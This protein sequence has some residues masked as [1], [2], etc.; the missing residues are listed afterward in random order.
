MH[1]GTLP[2]ASTHSNSA[3]NHRFYDSRIPNPGSYDSPIPIPDSRPSA[4]HRQHRDLLTIVIQLLGTH[5]QRFFGLLF[6]QVQA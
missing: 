1:I 6:E 5:D 2:L 4:P 3:A